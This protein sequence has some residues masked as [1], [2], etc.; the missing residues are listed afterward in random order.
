MNG[1]ATVQLPAQ[2]STVAPHVDWL[3]YFLYWMSVAF[4]VAIVGTALYFVYKY[5]R[6]PG[7]K[8][9]PTGHNNVLEVTWT[10]APLILVVFLFHA[11]FKGYVQM[12]VAPANSMEIQVRAYQWA[13]EFRYPNGSVSLNELHV[14]VNQPVRMVMTSDDVI[15]SF[16]V[17][18]FRIKQDV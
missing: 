10:F 15:H 18:A 16:Y 5:R 8:A 4:F 3:Y 6:R 2:M 9:A 11:G 13:W 17:P 1:E 14:P 7:V 12:R